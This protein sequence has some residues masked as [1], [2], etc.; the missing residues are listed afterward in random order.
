[1]VPGLGHFYLGDYEVGFTALLWNALF[2]WAAADTLRRG[3]WGPGIMLG[4]LELFWYSGTVYGAV[5]GAHRFNRDARL[6]YLDELDRRAGL[7]VRLLPDR[8]PPDAGLR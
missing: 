3:Q 6:N 5:A 8:L 4:A 1:M 7:D 2:G